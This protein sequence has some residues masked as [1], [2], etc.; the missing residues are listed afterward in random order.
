M[1]K[2]NILIT[3]G[4]GTIG[5][6]LVKKLTLSNHN[7]ISTDLKRPKLSELKFYN[8]NSNLFFYKTDITKKKNI[9]NLIKF[10]EKSS[11]SLDIIL[12]CA[13]PKTHDWIKKKN[14]NKVNEKSLFKNISDQLGGT[15]LLSKLFIDYLLKKKTKT[16]IILFSSIYGFSTPRFEDYSKN[17]ILTPVEYAAIKAGIIS[18]TKYFAKLYKKK[19][20][21]FNCVSPGGIKGKNQSKKFTLNYKKHC[22]SKGLLDADDLFG[23]IKFLISDSS[24]AING[25]NLIIDDGWSL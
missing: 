9:E 12:H 15:I 25:Q 20:I 24:K 4:L 19:N 14:I 1:E 11:L 18:I 8:Q 17:Q 10:I 3:G 21:Q 16:K 22:N 7:V 13:Y 5:S 23:L 2:K 6:N